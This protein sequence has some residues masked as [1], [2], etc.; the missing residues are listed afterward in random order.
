LESVDDSNSGID[1]VPKSA[2][3]SPEDIEEV[4]KSS[5]D[6]SQPGFY[7]RVCHSTWESYFLTEASCT[8]PPEVKSGC[9]IDYKTYGLHIVQILLTS[10]FCVTA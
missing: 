1:F 3:E 6:V 10:M 9:I 8:Q 2:S 7:K 5:G 4:L